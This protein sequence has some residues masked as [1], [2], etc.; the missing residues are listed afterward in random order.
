MNDV[1][2]MP[3]VFCKVFNTAATD[4]NAPSEM[5]RTLLDSGS[6]ECMINGDLA[7]SMPKVPLKQPRPFSTG[8][9]TVYITEA[10]TVTFTIPELYVDRKVSIQC[11]IMPKPT[12]YC[13]IVGTNL[14]SDLKLQ[15]DFESLTVTWDEAT[16]PFKSITA[17]TGN[18]NEHYHIADSSA[19]KE[20]SDRMDRIL[21]AKYERLNITGYIDSCEHLNTVEKSILKTL[22]EKYDILF[23]G[24]LGLWRDEEYDIEL[25][26]DAKPYHARAYPIPKSQE[27]TLR[28]EMERLCKAGVVRKVNRS[29]WAAPTFIIPKKDGTVRVIADFRKLNEWI[30]RRPFPIPRIQDLLLKLEGF[31]YA[32]SLDL[33]MGYYHIRLS[34]NSQVLCT[35]ILPWGKYEYLRLPMGLSNSPDIFQEKMS[36]LMSDLEY[37]R[38]YLDDLLVIT[39]GTFE[40]HIQKLDAVLAKLE[41]AGLKVNA[42]KSFFA[43]GELEYLG[44]WIT[45]NGLQPTKKK[46]DGIVNMAAPKTRKELISNS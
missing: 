14:L 12:D 38:T 27:Q 4:R 25:K 28:A 10:V 20:M 41:Y 15:L 2:K 40:D 46:I 24:T 30:V 22:L 18:I 19:T 31:K 13:F 36:E 33:N 29:T 26:P 3:I 1:P 39:N 44:Y 9:G 43:Q 35:I 34:P 8:N 37:V 32:T 11:N 21:E 42:K 6:S 17:H 7:F 16:I 5:I 23:D 45:R